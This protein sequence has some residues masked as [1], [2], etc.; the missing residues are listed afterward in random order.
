MGKGKS[1][2]YFKILLLTWEIM[3]YKPT[4]YKIEKLYILRWV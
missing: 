1:K 2:L 4:K 3:T